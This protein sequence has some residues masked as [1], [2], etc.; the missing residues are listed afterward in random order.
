MRPGSRTPLPLACLALLAWHGASAQPV[1]EETPAAPAPAGESPQAAPATPEAALEA[2][3]E[4]FRAA[5]AAGRYADAVVTG[6]EVVRLAQQVS[7]PLDDDVATALN[8]LGVAQ[9][10]AGDLAGAEESFGESLE[11]LETTQGIGSRRMIAPLAGLGATYMARDEPG[12]SAEAYERAIAVSRRALG[13]FNLEQLDLMDALISAYSAVGFTEGLDRE[14]RYAVQVVEQRYGLRDPRTLPRLLQ[15]AEW[16]EA[17]GRYLPSRTVYRRVLE[18]ATREGGPRN[19]QTVSALLA[20]ARTHRL[21]F[22]EDPES[23]VDAAESGAMAMVDPVTGRPVTRSQ[24]IPGPTP[25]PARPKLDPE[26]R[27]ALQEALGILD[28]A[29]DPPADL[30]ARA[31]VEYGDWLMTA[32]TPAQAMEH[33]RRAW[34]LLESLAAEGAANPLATPRRLA[35][36]PPVGQRRSRAL[37]GDDVA[38]R[39]GE[40]LLAVDA[41]GRVTAVEP[42]GG[43]LSDLQSGYVQRALRRALFS[44]AFADGEPTATTGY[45]VVESWLDRSADAPPAAEPGGDSSAG[46][47]SSAGPPEPE[48]D[49]GPDPA[50]GAAPPPAA[51]ADDP[52]PPGP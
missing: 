22:V 45:R 51:P 40:F 34:P 36:R 1:P 2:T 7:G 12:R 35:Y 6:Q 10:R 47:D 13:L 8:N 14:R 21:Q 41:N 19:P 49:D 17:S 43:T 29:V 50:A 30:L 3:Y 44:P 37:A 4:T 23:L 46:D 16:Y 5:F 42:V 52:P 28:S 27:K 39:V 31:L 48:F 38:E 33:Y 25:A 24:A 11:L 15:L 26:G 20:I 9:L 32:G 18:V